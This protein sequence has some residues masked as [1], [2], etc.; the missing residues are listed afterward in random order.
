MTIGLC[1]VT[2]VA[3]LWLGI[4]LILQK[5][6]QSPSQDTAQTNSVMQMLGAPGGDGGPPPDIG[7]GPPPDDMGGG[8]PPSIGGAAPSGGGSGG[9]T[10]A[11]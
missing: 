1:A 10:G 4:H 9:G 5:T 8:G 3:V 2:G 11:K 6:G 7:E